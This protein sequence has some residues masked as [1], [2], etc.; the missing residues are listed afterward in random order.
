MVRSLALA[1]PKC[2]HLPYL[3]RVSLWTKIYGLLH[4]YFYIIVLFS[5]D[6]YSPV[7]KFHSVMIF[8]LLINV[9]ILLLN[10]LVLI[11]HLYINF[12]SLNHYFLYLN[13]S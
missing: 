10:C 2:V 11:L 9:A 7:N 13:I 1:L 6:I 4:M 3:R 12:L 5:I 8:S